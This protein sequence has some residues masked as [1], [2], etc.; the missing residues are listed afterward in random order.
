[1]VYILYLNLYQR[2]FVTVFQ[3]EQ[4][5]EVCGVICVCISTSEEL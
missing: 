5:N 4:K 1:M 3:K 2:R